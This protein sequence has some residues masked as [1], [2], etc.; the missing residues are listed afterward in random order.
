MTNCSTTF[1]TFSELS[2]LRGE[3]QQSEI[4]GGANK[5]E[6]EPTE[7]RFREKFFDIL[8]TGD[9]HSEERGH[10]PS[11]YQPAALTRVRRRLII[12]AF[13]L[14]LLFGVDK[15]P[16]PRDLSLSVRVIL[17]ALQTDS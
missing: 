12:M 8:L 9:L 4:R 16:P 13:A 7:K 1:T 6:K 14:S 5:K 11:A 10:L 17:K 3:R 15:N 2:L